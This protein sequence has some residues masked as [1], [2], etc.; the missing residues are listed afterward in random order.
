MPNLPAIGLSVR[1]AKQGSPSIWVH[2]DRRRVSRLGRKELAAIKQLKAVVNGKT[3]EVF[4][5]HRGGRAEY[6]LDRSSW[7][8]LKVKGAKGTDVKIL[9]TSRALATV[10]L[11]GIQ[12][13]KKA[14]CIAGCR[15]FKY[16]VWLY[17][18]QDRL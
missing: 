5:R 8:Q 17:K 2:T 18:S 14:R 12:K 15:L 4:L 9:R 3:Q 1:L 16:F 10:K 11:T 7:T 6:S 13:V